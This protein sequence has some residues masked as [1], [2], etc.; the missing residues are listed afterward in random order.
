MAETL[1]KSDFAQKLILNIEE[2]ATLCN[3]TQRTIYKNTSL[4]EIPHY[5]QS[6]KLYFK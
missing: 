5:K 2:A 1:K 3:L 4:G 6:G